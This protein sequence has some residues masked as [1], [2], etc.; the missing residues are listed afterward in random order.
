MSLL[1]DNSRT[2]QTESSNETLPKNDLPLFVDGN[3]SQ[4]PELPEPSGLVELD[5]SEPAR[6]ADQLNELA[7]TGDLPMEPIPTKEEIM[8]EREEK[9]EREER[10]QKEARGRETEEKEE[11]REPV[12]RVAPAS[13]K[14]GGKKGGK[15]GKGKEKA[16]DQ[17][18]I[19]A[20]D[21][22]AG[23]ESDHE[24]GMS[25]RQAV[26]T[27]DRTY[28]RFI[29]QTL[30]TPPSCGNEAKLWNTLQRLR[31]SS[32]NYEICSTSND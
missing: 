28:P 11:K 22:E 1:T 26:T 24:E 5:T 2:K 20:E 18:A 10:K 14:K 4:A 9:E 31:S 29:L 17:D 12:K 16:I 25:N 7:E 8:Q 32:P 30:P 23:A 6:L 15:K 21:E 19:A 13:A 27:I 3:S